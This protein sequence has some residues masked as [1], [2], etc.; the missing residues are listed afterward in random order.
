MNILDH[1]NQSLTPFSAFFAHAIKEKNNR[2][3]VTM[4]S[5]EFCHSLGPVAANLLSHISLCIH[6]RIVELEVWPPAIQETKV[7]QS[8]FLKHSKLH[9]LAMQKHVFKQFH[10]F[11]HVKGFLKTCP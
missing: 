7:W 9:F 6:H 1:L 8:I 3:I 10:N 11:L 2:T 5:K 4:T